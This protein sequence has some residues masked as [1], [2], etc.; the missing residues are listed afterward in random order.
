M[1]MMHTKEPLLL[2]ERV[3]H[4]VAAGFP[5]S[6][7]EWSFTIC[8]TPYNRKSNVLSASLNKIFPSFLPYVLTM[9]VIK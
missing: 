9:T 8:P 7:S 4:V 5:L 2:N 3:A 6:L 1:M